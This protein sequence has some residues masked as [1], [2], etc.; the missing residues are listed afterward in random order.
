[1]YDNY[2]NFLQS[3]VID[4]LIHSWAYLVLQYS[5]GACEPNGMAKIQTQSYNLDLQ[6]RF[7]TQTYNLNMGFLNRAWL[8]DYKRPHTIN[9][10]SS[11][12]SLDLADI[13][14]QLIIWAKLTFCHFNSSKQRK[15]RDTRQQI[16]HKNLRVLVR[17]LQF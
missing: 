13:W 14:I 4:S 3:A 15:I 11:F 9:Q 16:G 6:L 17:M 1:M 5:Q 2:C 7:T 12:K 8:I 10:P